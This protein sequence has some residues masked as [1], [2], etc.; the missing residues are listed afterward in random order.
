MIVGAKQKGDGAP[1]LPRL[2][3]RCRP[4]VV[5]AFCD[6][7]GL[8]RLC[9][10]A[11]ACRC[12]LAHE[13]LEYFERDAELF[14]A[15]RS[16]LVAAGQPLLTRAQQAGTRDDERQN[17][18]SRDHG[19]PTAG[20]RARRSTRRVASSR[21]RPSKSANAITNISQPENV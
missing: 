7:R 8:R 11:L 13:L 17:D 2:S 18:G 10:L 4:V 14:K 5:P 20:R 3:N 19:R 1:A 12:V 15:C 21:W 16:S 6:S 9:A